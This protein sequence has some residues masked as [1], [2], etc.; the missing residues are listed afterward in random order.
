MGDQTLVCALP[1]IGHLVGLLLFGLVV[2]GC[3]GLASLDDLNALPERSL[4]PDG[5]VLVSHNEHPAQATIEGP[6]PAITADVLGTDLTPAAVYA[7][8]DD[9]LR[10]AGWTRDPG[11]LMSVRTTTEESVQVWRRGDVVARVAILTKGDPRNPPAAGYETL[12]ELAFAATVRQSFA[13]IPT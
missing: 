7:W 3:A 9:T 10:S 6:L 2:A 4:R 13:P 11:D 12:Y 5:A 1:R 8:Y